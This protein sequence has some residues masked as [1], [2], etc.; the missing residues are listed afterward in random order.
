[1]IM[2]DVIIKVPAGKIL[3][4]NGCCPKGCSLTNPEKKFAGKPAMSAVIRL[5]GKTGTIHFN[6]YFGVFEYQSDLDP[7]DGDLVD[8]YCPHCETSLSIQEECSLCQVPMFAIHL[9][10]GGELRACPKVGCRNHHLTIVD[11]DAQFAAFYN[12]ER[13]PKM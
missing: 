11:L 12:E 13:R 9:A 1:M 3:I 6:P 5:N 4:K 7:Q 8:L 2:E 10:D